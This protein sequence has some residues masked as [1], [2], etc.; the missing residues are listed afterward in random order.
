MSA[1]KFMGKGETKSHVG[2]DLSMTILNCIM[3]QE[4]GIRISSAQLPAQLLGIFSSLELA[5]QKCLAESKAYDGRYILEW[6]LNASKS[7]PIVENF[8]SGKFEKMR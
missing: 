5:E 2:A 8:R 1:V 4:G 3:F 6:E 7:G